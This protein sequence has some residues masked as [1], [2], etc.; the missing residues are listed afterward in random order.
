MKLITNLTIFTNS[1]HSFVSQLSSVID[2]LKI[3][4]EETP[5]LVQGIDNSVAKYNID[6]FT[7]V[8]V[9]GKKVRNDGIHFINT[10]GSQTLHSI[11]VFYC[12]YCRSTNLFVPFIRL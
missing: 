2:D 6:Q 1:F 10:A 12:Y 3:L 8:T 9:D 5:S 4:S 11:H 7:I